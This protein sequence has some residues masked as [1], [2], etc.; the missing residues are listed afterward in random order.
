MRNMA[1]L[2]FYGVGMPDIKQF[3]RFE[4]QLELL[5]SR[6]LVIESDKEALS[7]L[8][9]NNY[10]RL[11][12][13]TLTLR[14]DDK[15]YRG[16]SFS[17]ISGICQFDTEIRSALMYALEFIE[18]GFRTQIAYNH[19]EKH[20]PLGLMNS[21]GINDITCRA[22]VMSTI[23]HSLTKN[24]FD[25]LFI[26]H[27]K[28]RYNSMLPTWVAIE[29]FTFS[30]ISILFRCLDHDIKTKIAH[31]LGL[32]VKYIENWLHCLSI[33]RNICA[34][35]GRIYNRNLVKRPLLSH[36]DNKMGLRADRVFTLIFI[37]E[38]LIIDRSA[39][40]RFTGMLMNAINS[41]PEVKLSHLGFPENWKILLH[42]E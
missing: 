21:C 2:C 28:S 34:H 13:Y 19:A 9:A 32:P 3:R 14:K 31:E 24:S 26:E 8:S 18:I 22:H 23:A 37:M 41:H 36:S 25:E 20:G 4:E 39:W 6:G 27:H 10:Y 5:R 12:G 30:E 17:L 16:V 7:F 29:L 42:T 40:R 38:K 35:R 33:L 15:F 1:G 11:S